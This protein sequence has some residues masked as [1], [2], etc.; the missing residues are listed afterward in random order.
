MFFF[1]LNN[2]MVMGNDG[3][4]GDSR[5]TIIFYGCLAAIYTLI[6][7]TFLYGMY[8]GRCDAFEISKDRINQQEQLIKA[9][10]KKIQVLE[11]DP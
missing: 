9:M 6:G 11:I 10:E 4:G 8:R 1:F 3:G 5:N 2:F 7:A